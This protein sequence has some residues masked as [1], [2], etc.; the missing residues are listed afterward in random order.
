MANLQGLS[1]HMYPPLSYSAFRHV[2]VEGRFDPTVPT[3]TSSWRGAGWKVTSPGAGVFT[4]VLDEPVRQCMRCSARVMASDGTGVNPYGAQMLGPAADG[5]TFTIMIGRSNAAGVS[6]ALTPT[7][8][9][10][11]VYFQIDAEE[12]TGRLR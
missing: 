4:V 3:T 10:D 1:R 2:M 7:N 5:K 6:I 12:S 11:F 9:G 8:T